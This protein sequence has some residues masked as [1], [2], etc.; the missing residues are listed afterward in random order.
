IRQAYSTLTPL[1]YE[2]LCS[3]CGGLE[4]R[5]SHPLNTRPAQQIQASDIQLQ[6][7]KEILPENIIV[8]GNSIVLVNLAIEPEATFQITLQTQNIHDIYGRKPAPPILTESF[9]VPPKPPY[10]NFH[11]EYSGFIMEAAYPP[12]VLLEY[13]NIEG[14]DTRLKMGP[15]RT[16][17]Q[18]LKKNLKLWPQGY[19]SPQ[20]NEDDFD[21]WQKYFAPLPRF[22]L[23]AGMKRNRPNYRLL[24]FRPYL[25]PDVFGHVYYLWMDQNASIKTFAPQRP[26]HD[27]RKHFRAFQ[28][29]NLA[30][31]ARVGYNQAVAMVSHLN[32]GA[33]AAGVGVRLYLTDTGTPRFFEGISD[34]NGLVVLDLLSGRRMSGL[35]GE[36]S[37]PPNVPGNPQMRFELTEKTDRLEYHFRNDHHNNHYRY[38]SSP[39]RSVKNYDFV[40][41]DR[42]VYRPGEE[43]SFVGIS[44]SQTTR[45][46]AINPKT[47][48]PAAINQYTANNKQQTIQVLGGRNELPLL[49]QTL[50]T[51]GSNGVFSGSFAIP[52][53]LEPGTYNIRT[54]HGVSSFQIANLRRLNFSVSFRSGSDFPLIVGMPIQASAQAEY[55]AG[56]NLSRAKYRLSWEILPA[57]FFPE[58]GYAGYTFGPDDREERFPTA[59]EFAKEFADQLPPPDEE[60]LLDAQGNLGIY[61]ETVP[62]TFDP[63]RP[64]HY[65]PQLSVMDV[66]NQEISSRKT[67]TIHPAE[68][69]IGIKSEHF[70]LE[71]N[72]KNA[73]DIALVGP[74]SKPYRKSVAIKVEFIRREWQTVLQKG[75]YGDT[76]QGYEMV[77]VEESAQEHTVSGGQSR[78]HL[79]PR[80]NGSYTLRIRALDRSGRTAYSTRSM[81][82]SG[83]GTLYRADENA[84]KLELIADRELYSP[85]DTATILLQS[86]LPQSTNSGKYLLT[87]ER[88]GIIE[89]KVLELSGSTN[90]LEIPITEDFIPVVYAGISSYSPR[91]QDPPHEFGAPD[92]GKPQGYFGILP[93]LVRTDSRHIDVEVTPSR[94]IYQ[95]GETVQITLKT[96]LNGLPLEGANLVFLAVDRGVVDLIDYRVPDP[97]E[98]FYSLEK[99]PLRV[100]GA[101][102][103]AALLSPILYAAEDIRNS[104][105]SN[106][107]LQRERADMAPMMA[108]SAESRTAGPQ[109]RRNFNPTAVF[110][111]NLRSDEN[112]EV[113]FDFRLPD[114]LTTY[115][116]SAIAIS[117]NNF[118][119]QDGEIYVR[120]PIT[121]KAA[122]PRILREHDE[123]D[124]GVVASNRSSHSQRLEISAES[125]SHL[126]L[127]VAKRS[128]TLGAGETTLLAFPALARHTGE[129]LL[130]FE[131][132]SSLLEER[133]EQRIPVVKPYV[134]EQFTAVGKLDATHPLSR[135]QV[136]LPGSA[137]TGELSFQFSKGN[138]Q[139]LS[140]ALEHLRLS[141]AYTTE[142]MAGSLMPHV[143][144]GDFV[145]QID[146][147][148]EAVSKAEL[149]RRMRNLLQ[150][151]NPDGSFA[152]WQR[153]SG[154]ESRGSGSLFASSRVGFFLYIA[155]MSGYQLP[156]SFRKEQ[157]KSF[158]VD[159]IRQDKAHLSRSSMA[160]GYYAA[161]MLDAPEKAAEYA[162]KIM[163]LE[164]LRKESLYLTILSA[165]TLQRGGHRP[166]D[167]LKK[168]QTYVKPG[169]RSVDWV[170]F[171]D[172][173]QVEPLRSRNGGAVGDRFGSENEILALYLMLLHSVDEPSGL[174]E[175]VANTL[176]GRLREGGHWGSAIEDA[177]VVV[178]FALRR[179]QNRT[180]VP[181]P[182]RVQLNH[183]DWFQGEVLSTQDWVQRFHFTE[184][185]LKIWERDRAQNLAF[186]SNGQGDVYYSLGLRYSIPAEDFGPRDEGLGVF[187]EIVDMDGNI[188]GR[189]LVLGQ[190][191]RMNVHLSSSRQRS[192]LV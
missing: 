26:Y 122:T 177:M 63:G 94:P 148:A 85:G 62:H 118:G 139:V 51:D 91:T 185:P 180:G 65:I 59:P 86:P 5:F 14:R 20:N 89:H 156:R 182:V 71:K 96:Q 99:F 69:Y 97:I 136:I 82:A 81:Y 29:S 170:K 116:F 163:A 40:F 147:Q 160:F 7:P 179:N 11:G 120:N 192:H 123:A 1:R 107:F 17:R 103:R 169:T 6:P 127:R 87:L 58:S 2:S 23:A 25:N 146:L 48:N 24:D 184:A 181:T 189:D 34:E 143:L 104:G 18:T 44:R 30:I 154:V 90:R 128:I 161:A 83:S 56:G 174:A 4:I 144:L 8:R 72:R 131:V 162:E 60:G 106:Y 79:K 126:E 121:I 150:L 141:A 168:I 70:F 153:Q 113:R 13:Q 137:E 187:Y 151:Q 37:R 12:K 130:S 108:R 145:P 57:R 49:T 124:L 16:L 178:A 134:Y 155:E 74:D 46:P 191:Y 73:F 55:L 188:M 68:F 54:N 50:E 100:Q 88:E 42:G 39:Y 53:N 52:E 3:D 36:N 142:Q 186:L 109:T 138:F 28:V 183:Q 119:R 47:I 165:L 19:L 76:V 64:Y 115:R 31:T 84:A 41:T 66:D 140:G 92:S 45:P 95:P 33:A 102:S 10:M 152:L 105:H 167:L 173:A 61:R 149:R 190:T 172:V 164:T 159:S 101:E 110:R 9:Q 98:Y 67:F 166:E 22:D 133:L 78:I 125:S 75:P 114:T 132:D 117:Q 171:Q 111:S 35:R 15:Y 77:E 21:T 135:E 27:F 157:L 32:D 129:A 80:K 112:G 43:L 158:I 176:V 38:P 175:K 93:L